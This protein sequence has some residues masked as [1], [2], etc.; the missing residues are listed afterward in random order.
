MLQG[1]PTVDILASLKA[2]DYDHK[3]DAIAEIARNEKA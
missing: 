1:L 3:D 2:L